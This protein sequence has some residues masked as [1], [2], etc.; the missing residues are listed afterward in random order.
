[1]IDFLFNTDYFIFL[2]AL[3]LIIGVVATKF[4]S[5]FGV[6][7]LVL[8]IVVGMIA[9]DDGL[10]LIEFGNASLAKLFGM[11]A[12]IIIL[13]EGGLQTKW[14]AVKPVAYPAITLATLGVLL[15][16][17]FT[18]IAARFILDLT[19]LEA[20]LFGSIVGSTDAAAVFA[21]LRGK[22]IKSR[23]GTTLEAESASNDPMAM[24]LTI[25]FIQ[26]IQTDDSSILSLIPQFF[27]QMGIGLLIGYVLGKA[28]VWVLNKINLDSGGLYPVLGL[29][30]AASTYGT[31]SLIGASGLLAVY[32]VA[33]VI[34]NAEI[35]YRHMITR[36]SEGLAWMMQ[37]LMFV[38]LGLLVFPSEI[39]GPIML[40]GLLLSLIL[41]LVA[42]PISVFVIVA[43]FKYRLK[44]NIFLAWSGLRGAVPIVLATFPM[45]AGLEQS[46]MFFNVIFFVVLTSALIQGSTISPL[47]SKLGLVEDDQPSPAHSIELVSIGKTNAE[48][49]EYVVKDQ[50]DVAHKPIADLALPEN[51]LINAIIRND[52]VITP[53]GSTVIQPHDIL[54]ILVNKDKIKDLKQALMKRKKKDEFDKEVVDGQ[55]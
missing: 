4:S 52:E 48:I 17:V 7:A 49:I 26:L 14:D 50:D 42:R 38:V 20:L 30:I 43:F 24:F 19:W 33:I 41:M 55:Y 11:I 27:W 5:K 18:G 54:F 8:F 22:N 12:L 47:A 53:F 29:G 28:G 35:P 16:A 6:P 2:F 32:V 1:M 51:A 34:G 39:I 31:A 36:F 9:G 46:Q 10:G 21:V 23:L 37:I 15:T 40:K 3:L 13:F 25:S 44:E 45:L